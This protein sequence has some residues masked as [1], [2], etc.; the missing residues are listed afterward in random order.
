MCFYVIESLVTC[1]SMLPNAH[2][3]GLVIDVQAIFCLVVQKSLE[4]E[5]LASSCSVGTYLRWL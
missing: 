4:E 1:D 3:S 5:L 2:R